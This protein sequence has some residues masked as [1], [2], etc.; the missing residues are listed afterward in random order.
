MNDRHEN[1]TAAVA[2]TLPDCVPTDSRRLQTQHVIQ[3]RTVRAVLRYLVYATLPSKRLSSLHAKWLLGRAMAQA[4]PGSIPG[5]SMWDL[6][7]TKWHWDRFCPPVLRFSPV[8]FIPPVLHSSTSHALRLRCV[9]SICCG[10]LLKP[11]ERIV[12]LICKTCVTS[13]GQID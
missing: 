12:V 6:W 4:V 11:S 13:S 2:M 8:N 7:W 5:H 10:A 1:H 9:R 3:A